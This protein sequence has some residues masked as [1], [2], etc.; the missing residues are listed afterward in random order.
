MTTVYLLPQNTH[1]SFLKKLHNH[2]ISGGVTKKAKKAK[3][4]KKEKKIKSPK[5]EKK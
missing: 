4:P 2:P 5:K 3:S 1:S